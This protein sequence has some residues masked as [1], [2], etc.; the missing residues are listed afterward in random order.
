MQSLVVFKQNNILFVRILKNVLH[1][2]YLKYFLGKT[3][4][5]NEETKKTLESKGRKGA[6]K[7][8]CSVMFRSATAWPQ[9][10][11][12]V[13]S[14]I[15]TDGPEGYKLVK[16]KIRTLRIPQIGDKFASRHGQKGVVGMTFNETVCCEAS[17]YLHF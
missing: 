15:L 13:D 4:C 10:R 9:S 6:T 5:I 12:F 11:S 1:I 8:D 14:I 3:Q 2:N 17:L 7:T 16:V